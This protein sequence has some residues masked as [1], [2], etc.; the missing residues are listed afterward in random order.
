MRFFGFPDSFR[1]QFYAT[2]FIKKGGTNKLLAGDRP[3]SS[4]CDLCGQFPSFIVFSWVSLV[5]HKSTG[6][7]LAPPN[8]SIGSVWP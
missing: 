3:F 2:P 5:T 8:H 6:P 4:H 7:L 1:A